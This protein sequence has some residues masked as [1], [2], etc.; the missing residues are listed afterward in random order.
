[1]KTAGGGVGGGGRR[2]T[3]GGRRDLSEVELR[4]WDSSRRVEER[5]RMERSMK[6]TMKMR[7]RRRRREVILP[8]KREGRSWR[9]LNEEDDQAEAPSSRGLAGRSPDTLFS[10]STTTFS[11]N[12][13]QNV[14]PTQSSCFLLPS[15][16]SDP[17]GEEGFVTTLKSKEEGRKEQGEINSLSAL[18]FLLPLRVILAYVP[19]PH[20]ESSFTS[21]PT[22][23]TL[24]TD[25]TL[26]SALISSPHLPYS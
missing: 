2:T 23:W 9:K 3:E 26:I 1:M 11:G 13:E 24:D 4:G 14:L 17:Y 8:C 16:S 12:R 15:A 20:L 19:L 18:P 22:R 21:Q 7:R 10:L 5:R 25:E 6:V